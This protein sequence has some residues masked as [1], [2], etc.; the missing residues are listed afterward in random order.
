MRTFVEASKMRN[1][2]GT[3]SEADESSG[4]EGGIPSRSPG[5]VRQK[6]RQARGCSFVDSDAA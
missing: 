4:L 3:V 6:K 5:K 2:L 1:D